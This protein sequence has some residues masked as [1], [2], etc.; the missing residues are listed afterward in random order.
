MGVEEHRQFSVLRYCEG[1]SKQNN[2]QLFAR[3][4]KI[5]PQYPGVGGKMPSVVYDPAGHA[6]RKTIETFRVDAPDIHWMEADKK[7]KVQY[8][9][10]LNTDLRTGKT[11]VE[12]GSPMIREAKRLRWKRPGQ[13]AENAEHSDLGDSWLYSWRTARN[14]LRELPVA[15]P[16]ILKDPMDEYLEKMEEEKTAHGGYFAGRNRQRNA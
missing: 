7:E 15:K 11:F 5:A 9:E 6:T 4:R 2:H 10:W 12:R 3:I 8:I 13:L 16:K 14:L 1:L